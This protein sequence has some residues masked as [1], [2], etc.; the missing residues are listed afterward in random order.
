MEQLPPRNA[1]GKLHEVT[2]KVHQ[3]NCCSLPYKYKSLN[4]FRDNK[5]ASCYFFFSCLDQE[6]QG[7][8]A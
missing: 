4:Y 3:L 5:R 1:K 7:V 6:Q 8:S 2:K